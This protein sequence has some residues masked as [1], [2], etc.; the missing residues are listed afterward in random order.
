MLCACI[1]LDTQRSALLRMVELGSP[2][3]SFHHPFHSGQN[4]YCEVLDATDQ[5]PRSIRKWRMCAVE[6]HRCGQRVAHRTDLVCMEVFG[7]SK[8]KKHISPREL[9]RREEQSRLSRGCNNRLIGEDGEEIYAIP[10]KSGKAFL[11]MPE[12]F[13]QKRM[14]LNSGILDIRYETE[15]TRS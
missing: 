15:Y 11:L 8:R 10:Q 3:V 12:Y 5:Q 13:P 9:K 2:V 7:M 14:G 4:R 1:A 6:C